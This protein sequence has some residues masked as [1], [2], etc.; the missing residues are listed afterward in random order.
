[1]AVCADIFFLQLSFEL[2]LHFKSSPI[3]SSFPLMK[4]E[5]SSPSSPPPPQ[6]P[7]PRKYFSETVSPVPSVQFGSAKWWLWIIHTVMMQLY[8]S[9]R[10]VFPKGKFL[11]WEPACKFW[12]FPPVQHHGWVSGLRVPGLV[13]PCRGPEG[14]LVFSLWALRHIVAGP[15]DAGYCCATDVHPAAP[16][17]VE[18]EQAGT[19]NR[20]SGHSRRVL[21]N[22]GDKSS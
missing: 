19:S 14:H 4:I 5:T 9:C 6:R 17:I 15:Q 10:F 20:I 11:S 12:G 1:M 13:A 21:L 18:A 8:R 3:C 2:L 16:C 7:W 22:L